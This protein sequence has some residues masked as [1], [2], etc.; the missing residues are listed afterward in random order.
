LQKGIGEEQIAGA[1]FPVTT[2]GAVDEKS[3]AFMDTAAILKNLDLF[4]T[5]DSAIA[6]LAGGLGVPVWLLLPFAP[7]WR[8]LRDRAD[9]PW[10]PTMRLFRQL[11]RRDWADVFERV[12]TELQ[13]LVST[14]QRLVVAS[15]ETRA[16]KPQPQPATI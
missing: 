7:D 13:R 5:S 9:S 11:K 8:W 4:I 16:G 1:D 12:A 6:H 2:L 14:E 3:G 15:V 10:Y